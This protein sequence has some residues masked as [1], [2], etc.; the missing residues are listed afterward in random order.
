MYVQRYGYVGGRHVLTYSKNIQCTIWMSKVHFGLHVHILEV[1]V[2]ILNGHLY[3]WDAQ[4]H[5][6]NEQ[7]Y[8][9]DVQEYMWTCIFVW[10]CMYRYVYLDRIYLSYIIPGVFH[11]HHMYPDTCMTN[12]PMLHVLYKLIYKFDKVM[13]CRYHTVSSNKVKLD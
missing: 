11:P 8:I 7:L 12:I 2:Y 10:I 5:I 3:I 4:L 1:K 9:W 13:L 6:L